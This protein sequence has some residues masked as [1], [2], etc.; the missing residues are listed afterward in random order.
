[1]IRCV[2]EDLVHEALKSRVITLDHLGILVLQDRTLQVSSDEKDV[3]FGDVS[4][5]QSLDVPLNS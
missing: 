3:L 1:M 4:L 5:S 2:S